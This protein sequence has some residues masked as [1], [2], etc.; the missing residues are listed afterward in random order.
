VP[1]TDSIMNVVFIQCMLLVPHL[2]PIYRATFVLKTYPEWWKNLVT[3]MLRKPSKPNY[4]IPGMHQPI[5]S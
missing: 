1:G 5:P 2:S 3:V 4:T